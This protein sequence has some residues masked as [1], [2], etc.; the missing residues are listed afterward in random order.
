MLAATLSA[1]DS[2]GLGVHEPACL[3]QHVLR[4]QGRVARELAG[5]R[6]G[7]LAFASGPEAPGNLN[8]QPCR[9]GAHLRAK[10]IRQRSAGLRHG[11][12]EDG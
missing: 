4:G 7:P 10:L 5:A 3:S 1:D 2:A 6:E 12:S 9:R 11:W 8:E